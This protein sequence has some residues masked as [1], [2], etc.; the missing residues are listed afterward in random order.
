MNIQLEFWIWFVALIIFIL[1]LDLWIFNKKSHEITIKEALIWS[2]VWIW[3]AILFSV[4]IFFWLWYEKTTEFLTC[5]VI[6]KSLSVDNLFV[7]ILIFSYFKIEKKY[8]HKVLFWWILW[9]IVMRAIFIFVWVEIINI[10]HF[11]IYFFWAFLV[12]NWIKLLFDS[13]KDVNFEEKSY[14]KM[15]KKIF[16]L[17]KDGNS[18]KFFITVAWKKYATPLLLALV[19]LEFSD[20]IFAVDSIPAVLGMSNDLFIVYSSNIFAIFWLRSLY[21][22]LASIIWKFEYLK[23]WLACILSFIWLKML[24]SWFY[25]IST[26]VSLWVITTF[27]FS[28]I[29]IPFVIKKL[30]K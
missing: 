26:L 19:T 6:E 23:Y 2:W 15:I 18:W 25:E 13:E 9:A 10:F 1:S 28:S 4:V 17:S 3:L 24:I 29:L 11:I 14:Y 27:L 21:F 12:F 7:F 5:Y 20:L 8:Q 30:K 22:L 16:L